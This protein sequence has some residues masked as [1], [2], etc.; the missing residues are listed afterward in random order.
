ME[1]HE[2]FKKF[3]RWLLK[4]KE[5]VRCGISLSGVVF[6]LLAVSSNCL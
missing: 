6:S 1:I 4:E 5:V 2:A 3:K